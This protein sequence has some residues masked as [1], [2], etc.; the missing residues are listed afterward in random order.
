M[1]TRKLFII[2]LLILSFA[3][4]QNN[5]IAQVSFGSQHIISDQATGTTTVYAS[6]IDNDEY[7]DVLSASPDD[8]KIA[9][10]R[11]LTPTGEFSEE[12][13]ISLDVE[14]AH[15]VITCDIDGDGDQ[16]VFAGGSMAYDDGGIYWFENLDANG[17]FGEAQLVTDLVT[18]NIRM[19]SADFDGDGDLDIVAI[20]FNSPIV[21]W[22][23][24]LDGEGSFGEQQ[25]IA[26]VSNTSCVDVADFNNDSYMDVV[27]GS[28][29]AGNIYWYPNDGTGI[30]DDGYY[31]SG[32][33]PKIRDLVVCD[34]NNDGEMDVLAACWDDCKLAWYENLGSGD[35]GSEHIIVTHEI[36]GMISCF[37]S[38]LDN[39]GDLDALSTSYHDNKVLWYENLGGGT[40]GDENMITNQAAYAHSV[41]ACD[42]DHDGDNDVLSA[43]LAD[44]KIAWYRNH[45][46]TAVE[47]TAAMAEYALYPNPTTGALYIQMPEDQDYSL[48]LKDLS[49]KLLMQKKSSGNQ[50]FINV[51]SLA[52]G[53][54]VLSIKTAKKT[55]TQRIVKK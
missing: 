31:V 38:D 52:N 35:F 40:F 14:F 29:G 13:I 23:E 39:D 16:D 17:N 18:I 11:N 43:S 2:A 24:N 55:K 3:V 50:G 37:V 32:S 36:G 49:G 15:E 54:Y 47:Q 30:F 41:F 22:Y 4:M 5:I 7:E 33:T 12:I 19:Q 1:K 28:H 27:V 8:N 46:I 10:Y 6:H 45:L 42:L 21:A 53:V 26:Y 34:M 48:E 51:E 20:C 25:I 9:W 44:D